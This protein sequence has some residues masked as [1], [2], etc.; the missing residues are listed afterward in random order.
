[1]LISP[2]AAGQDYASD[3]ASPTTTPSGGGAQSL[4]L[5]AGQTLLLTNGTYTR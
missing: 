3:C 5:V 4:D 1:L 2:Y